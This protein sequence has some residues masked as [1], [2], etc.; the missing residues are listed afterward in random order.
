MQNLVQHIH[1]NVR[2]PKITYH[3]AVEPGEVFYWDCAPGSEV[4]TLSERVWLTRPD[5]DYD[6]WLEPGGVLRLPERERIRISTDA[7]CTAEISVTSDYFGALATTD[8]WL[9]RLVSIFRC[10]PRPSLRH[11]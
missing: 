4:R 6:Y 5:C 3:F 9:D 10:R 2:L 1:S 7:G 8:R 11:L